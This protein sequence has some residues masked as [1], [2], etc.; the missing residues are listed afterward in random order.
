MLPFQGYMSGGAGY[1]LSRSALTKFITEAYNDQHLCH[2]KTIA[3]DEQLGFCMENIGVIA[4][5]SR[6]EKGL[7]RFVPL[8]PVDLY[9]QPA[10][11]W[12]IKGVKHEPEKVNPLKVSKF[13]SLFSCFL[14]LFLQNVS[15]CSPHAI[16]F[17]YIIPDYFYVLEYF[18]YALRPF[19]ISYSHEKLP[20]KLNISLIYASGIPD[21]EPLIAP[22]TT[23]DSIS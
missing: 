5:D 13:I 23:V 19:G 7:E 4:G 3:E 15:C 18:L 17:H 22:P 21:A 20:Q 8:P 16:S 6:D 14:F 10:T 11:D 2:Y 9:P 12:Y 1:V